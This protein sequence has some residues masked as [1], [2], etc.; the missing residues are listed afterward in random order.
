MTSVRF[1]SIQLLGPVDPCGLEPAPSVTDWFEISE[2]L[3][4]V[5]S[6]E[7][8]DK[9]LTGTH[10]IRGSYRGWI[11]YL[12]PNVRFN[13]NDPKTRGVNGFAGTP[14]PDTEEKVTLRVGDQ[15]YTATVE[16]V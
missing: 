11:M 16:F 3:E 15:T 7:N 14:T 12:Y 5:G 1:T 13:R 9:L 10:E 6:I 2:G 8:A 4:G